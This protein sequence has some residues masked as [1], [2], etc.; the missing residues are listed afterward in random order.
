MCRLRFSCGMRFFLI[1]SGSLASSLTLFRSAVEIMIEIQY[2]KRYPSEVAIYGEK[3]DKHNRQMQMEGKFIQR[4]GNLRFKTIGQLMKTLRKSGNLSAFEDALI[5]KWE[6][7]SGFVSHVTP[8]LHTIAQARP[9]WAWA[10]AFGELE[11]VTSCAIE[12]VRNVDES[13]G[14]LIDQAEELNFE[15]RL[16][17]LFSYGT[18]TS[19]LD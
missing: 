11:Q 17:N 1:E 16:R 9:E 4:R 7:L 3:V 14:H 6:L 2:L 5:G 15:E 19:P 12:Q 8:E 10:S 18:S 13:L